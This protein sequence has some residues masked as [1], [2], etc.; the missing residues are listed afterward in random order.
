MIK[1]DGIHGLNDALSYGSKNASNVKQ[2]NTLLLLFAALALLISGCAIKIPVSTSMKVQNIPTKKVNK[3]M[4]VVMSKEQ[5]QKIILYKKSALA[6]PFLFE[7][8]KSVSLNLTQ[9]MQV[10]FSSAEFSNDESSSGGTYDF[11]LVAEIKDAKFDFP[12]LST[13]DKRVNVYIDYDLFGT[14]R[15]KLLHLSTDG[16]SIAQ[17][18]VAEKVLVFFPVLWSTRG[19]M[20]IDRIGQAWDLAVIN[21]ITQVMDS[22]SRQFDNKQ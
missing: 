17:A 20:E 3:K 8:G 2:Y 6:N 9:A 11:V 19:N 12:F 18:S 1:S 21:S 7:A 5:E 15:G 16:N 14:D 10:M 22:M 4:L 13:A